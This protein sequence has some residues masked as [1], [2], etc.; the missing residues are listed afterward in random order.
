MK[1]NR[2]RIHANDKII[3]VADDLWPI[4]LIARYTIVGLKSDLQKSQ[5][6][7]TYSDHYALTY[8]LTYN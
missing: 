3:F 5:K 2:L 8:F 1:F 4:T 6:K 7:L